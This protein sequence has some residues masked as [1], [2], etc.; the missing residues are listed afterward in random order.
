[1]SPLV[2]TRKNLHL[3]FAQAPS[4]VA[5]KPADRSPR[6][7]YNA[8]WIAAQA[9]ARGHTVLMLNRDD[10]SGLPGLRLTPL[11]GVN[12]VAHTS[13][14]A[15][16]NPAIRAVLFD[17]GRVQAERVVG[18]GESFELGHRMLALLNF[19]VEKLFYLAAV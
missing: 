17:A 8:L 6:P 1:M 18:D 3:Y 5:V 19:G 16:Q 11:G 14:R 15:R 10:F 7:S 9:I 4:A 2:Q 12:A 13:G